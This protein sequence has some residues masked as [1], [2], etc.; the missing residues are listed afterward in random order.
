MEEEKAHQ[1]R[2]NYTDN[3]QKQIRDNELIRIRERQAFFE[4][5]VKLDEEAKARRAKLDDIKKKKLDELRLVYFIYF[6]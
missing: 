3:L 5:G 2:A 1:R 6:C 4:E